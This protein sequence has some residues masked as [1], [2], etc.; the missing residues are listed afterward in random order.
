MYASNQPIGLRQISE[1]IEGEP[2]CG[3][4]SAVLAQLRQARQDRNASQ[5][6]DARVKLRRHLRQAHGREIPLFEQ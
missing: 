1:Q 3:P 5:E 4:C 6:V 2:G